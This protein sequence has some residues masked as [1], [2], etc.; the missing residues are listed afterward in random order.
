VF[1][2][3][4]GLDLYEYILPRRNSVFK[5]KARECDNALPGQGCC[6]PQG[7]VIDD[8]RAVVE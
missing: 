6:T 2:V 8:H 4:Y 3:R 5:L 7:V 1:P